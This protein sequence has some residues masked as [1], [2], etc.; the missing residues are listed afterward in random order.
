MKHSYE[1]NEAA[2]KA[3]KLGDTIVEGLKKKDVPDAVCKLDTSGHYGV[4]FKFTR[5]VH[6]L[7]IMEGWTHG[8]NSKPTGEVL[9]RYRTVYD[10]NSGNRPTCNGLHL[11]K[12]PSVESIINN[13]KTRH[14][15]IKNAH[16]EYLVTDLQERT[17]K[18]ESKGL[19]KEFPRFRVNIEG[20]YEEG[21]SIHFD[22]LPVGRARQILE[23]LNKYLPAE[24]EVGEDS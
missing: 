2:K 6:A 7:E 5:E 18:L 3:N 17:F 19:A 13:L 15:R 9:V 14:T 8:F 16:E 1:S 10:F 4:F 21:H 22:R 24:H 12:L 11:S 20:D 23:V